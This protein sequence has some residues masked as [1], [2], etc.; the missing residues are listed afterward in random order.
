MNR[1]DGFPYPALPYYMEDRLLEPVTTVAVNRYSYDRMDK[2]ALRA[3]LEQLD[4]GDRQFA[5]I[6]GVPWE[7][8]DR[9]LKGQ[10]DIPHAVAVML[11]LL[12][13]PGAIDLA[14]RYTNTVAHDVRT[15][16]SHD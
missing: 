12:T 9:W 10:D 4:L 6:Y 1:A 3:A 14:E 2:R 13:L 15:V 7:R 16:R 5:K 11:A 8:V